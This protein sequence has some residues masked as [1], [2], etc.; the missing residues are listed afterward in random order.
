[1]PGRRRS[2]LLTDDI[3]NCKP[4]ERRAVRVR[5]YI[6]ARAIFNN[7][8]STIDCHIRN[9]S[10]TGAKLALSSSVGLP[11]AFL[12]EV[13]SRNRTFNAEL[14]WRSE[15]AVGV[16]FVG[17]DDLSL[18]GGAE[19]NELSKLRAENDVLRRR[20]SELVFR[21]ADLGHSERPD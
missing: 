16:E 13:P 20:V 11:G 5:A 6:G 19:A 15:D 14:R 21:L 17:L 4:K 3:A 10:S 1:V 9:I 18:G 7:G 8:R 12:L 2:F